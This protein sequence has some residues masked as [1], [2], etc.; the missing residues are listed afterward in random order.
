MPEAEHRKT[1]KRLALGAFLHTDG[2]HIG[3][4]RTPDAPPGAAFDFAHYVRLAQSAERAKFDLVFLADSSSIRFP[5]SPALHHTSR[6][7]HLE[8][9]TLLSALAPLTR[10]VGLVATASTTYNDPFNLARRF[11]SLDLLS[12][13]RA[14][15][16]LVTSVNE[17]EPFNFGL[18]APLA[19]DERYRRAAEFAAV[20]EGLWD[21]WDEG[22]F[23]F[24][25]A[26]GVYF[27]PAKL[28][29][30][31]HRGP[32]FQVRGPLNVRPSPQGRPVLV[33]AGASQDGRDLAAR[34]A[35]VIFS[36]HQTFAE[37]REFYADVKGRLALY[38]RE[39]DDL[40]ILPG[41]L[42]VVGRTEAEAREKFEALQALV[43][44]VVG[45]SML[46]TI[47]A[48][49]DLSAYPLDG[50]LPDLPESN[51]GKSRQRLL[52]DLARRE[53]L[54][55][56]QLYLRI[57][58]ARG[59]WQIVGTAAQIVDELEYHFVNGAADG[60]NVMPPQ[61]P[62]GLDDFIALVVPELQRRGLFRTEYEGKTLRDH[63]GLRRP[64]R[65]QVVPPA[66]AAA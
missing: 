43:D 32:Y 21:S 17:A 10:R 20:V 34:S 44:P 1:G 15:W 48:G 30:L 40:K 38:G 29:V 18:E 49:V 65:R 24:D 14:G 27:D 23:H 39:P 53:N 61:L 55:I 16:N 19:H 11:A 41:V 28:H 58:G 12:G 37:A 3:A 25:K 60:F 22:A 5:E 52:V 31:D 47:N 8:P 4:W 57:A 36:A 45:L 42:P 13:G 66:V 6:A 54:T 59:H 2:H 51:S 26:E 64:P 35:E 46:N 7:A 56:R 33:Q 9:F 50:P 62:A 63:L